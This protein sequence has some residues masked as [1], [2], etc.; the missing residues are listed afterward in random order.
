MKLP[1]AMKRVRETRGRY[2]LSKED[3]EIH[4]DEIEYAGTSKLS[5]LASLIEVRREI[6]R[7][8]MR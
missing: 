2:E 1:R 6:D 3:S 5:R 7:L 8:I 4:S